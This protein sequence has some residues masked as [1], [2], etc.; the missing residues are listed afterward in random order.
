MLRVVLL[1]QYY[2]SCLATASVR[3]E[4]RSQ[5]GAAETVCVGFGKAIGRPYLRNATRHEGFIRRSR[6]NVLPQPRV[7]F[8]NVPAQPA[9]GK[10][11]WLTSCVSRCMDKQPPAS[12]KQC[13]D[14]GNAQ[15][16]TVSIP[17]QTPPWRFRVRR[18][19]STTLY[20]NRPPRLDRRETRLKGKGS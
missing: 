2:V 16:R 20:R 12:V 3:R 17:K 14:L 10:E 15:G 5:R 1:K 9:I 4:E 19:P 11:K 8:K 13:Q 6:V 18:N 7:F